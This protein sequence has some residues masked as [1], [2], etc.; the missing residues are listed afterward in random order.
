[1]NESHASALPAARAAH[2]TLG[3]HLALLFAGL[4]GLLILLVAAYW[5]LVFEPSILTHAESHSNAYAQAEAQG[6]EQVLSAEYSPEQLRL[7]LQTALD[8]I[9][10]VRDRA[11]REP[12]I[13]RVEL[14][15]DYDLLDVPPGSL[16]LE[17]GVSVCPD[18]FV[19]E[20]LLYDPRSYLLVGVARLYSNPS[21]VHRQVVKLRLGLLWVGAI[22]LG[23]IGATGIVVNRLIRRL[24]ESEGNLRSV[25]E[26]APIPMMLQDEGCSDLSQANLAA[27]R[28]LGLDRNSEGLWSSPR[29][30][31]LNQEHLHDCSFADR[32]VLV[33][34]DKGERLWALASAVSLHFSGRRSRLI[35]LS[36]IS[37]IKAVQEELRSASYTDGLTGIY[38]RRYLFLRLAKEIDLHQRYHQPFSII[39]LDLDHFKSIN[40]THGHRVGDEVLVRVAATLRQCTRTVDVIGRHGGEEFL[41]IMPQTGIELALRIAER[42]R[43]AVRDIHWNRP[44]LQVTVS[45]GVREFDGTDIDGFVEAAD[46][47][48]YEAKGAGRDRVVG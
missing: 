20:A 2:K 31:A 24:G 12:F 21:F 40:D 26:A 35:A 14:A 34:S 25:F 43:V 1:M 48:L 38:N 46:H 4:A 44:G 5:L 22:M 19:T 39:L 7:A 32:E 8:A 13:M 33:P 27:R 16:D 28:Y 23:L 3:E 37:Q 47:C 6:I 11:T 45:A 42:I 41:I 30:Q 18:C 17:G 36:D 29:W 9:L 15:F 10:L